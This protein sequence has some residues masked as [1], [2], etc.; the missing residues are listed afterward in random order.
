VNGDAMPEPRAPIAVVELD[1]LGHGTDG[2]EAALTIDGRYKGAAV[3]ATANGE[4]VDFV[5]VDISGGRITSTEVREMLDAAAIR[6]LA[7]HLRSD[8]E[9][10]SAHAMPTSG[11]GREKRKGLLPATSI[12]IPT[13]EAPADLQACLESVVSCDYSPDRYEIVVVD[14][15]PKTDRTADVV[16]RM[17]SAHPELRFLYLQDRRGGAARAR[18][19]GWRAAGSDLVAFIDG[20][21]TVRPS[22]LRETIRAFGWER[23]VDC[24]TGVVLPRFLE[25]EAQVLFQQFGGYA[26]GFEPRIYTLSEPPQGHVLF[27]YQAGLFGTG[28]SMAFRRGV[29]EDLGG[30]DE[31]L[32][33][34]TP[35]RSGDDS[36]IL[37]R[38]ILSG[39]NL[40]YNPKAV[41]WHPD[42]ET[43][44]GLYAQ[45]RGYG[46]GLGAYLTRTA[47]SDKRHAIGIASR[48]GAG[49][50]L[51]TRPNSDKN[52]H[53]GRTYPRG[54]KVA[55]LAGLVHGPGAY[56]MSRRRRVK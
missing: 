38:T 7:V 42:E 15:A 50:A 32:G 5:Y 33:P 10:S 25:T 53:R 26:K 52:Q 24:V 36:E 2:G 55:E 19:V 9:G 17:K 13:R 31:S 47:L 20:D 34:G 11:P 18:N 29:L 21:V 40:A 44:R 8:Q 41:V 22:W 46:I 6:R 51:L 48:V 4:A 30:L 39:A 45:V 23:A 3:L 14:S 43:M 1:L 35:T 54:L 16:R 37:L 12:V 49:L 56:L 27:P 28:G